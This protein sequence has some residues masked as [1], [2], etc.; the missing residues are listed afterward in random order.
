MPKYIRT[1]DGILEAK[2]NCDFRLGKKGYYESKN[3]YCGLD[4]FEEVYKWYLKRYIKDGVAISNNLE[5][6]CDESVL[7]RND[8]HL[9]E[10]TA[11]FEYAKRM[12][13]QGFI[14]YGAIW[15][16]KGLIYVAKM[17]EKGELELL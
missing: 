5:E 14:V 6:L 7:I 1:K 3:Y 11:N 17:N 16:D 8:L 12:A 10:R 13:K 2:I 15:T 9:N 4:C